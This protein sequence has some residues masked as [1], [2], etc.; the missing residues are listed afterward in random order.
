MVEFSGAKWLWG[1]RVGFH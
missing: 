1:Q